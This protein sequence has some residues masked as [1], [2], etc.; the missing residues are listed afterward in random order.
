METSREDIHTVWY[1]K[2]FYC[3]CCFFS[4]LFPFVSSK[5]SAKSYRKW[6]E[7]AAETRGNM[8]VLFFSIICLFVCLIVFLCVIYFLVSEMYNHIIVPY[9]KENNNATSKRTKRWLKWKHIRHGENKTKTR[10]RQKK[11]RQSEPN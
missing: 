2:N 5:S 6:G 3:C 10:L 8:H 4:N 11:C 1:F 9:M 7:I